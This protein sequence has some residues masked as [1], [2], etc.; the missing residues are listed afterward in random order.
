MDF[1]RRWIIDRLVGVAKA[2]GD[3]WVV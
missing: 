1:M 3:E 2:S